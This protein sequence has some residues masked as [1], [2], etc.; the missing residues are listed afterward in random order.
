MRKHFALLIVSFLVTLNILGQEEKQR[1]FEINGTI[2]ADTGKVHLSFVHDYNLNHIDELVVPIKDNK[3]T[4]SGYITEPQ[5]VLILM[6]DFYR[7]SYFIIDKGTQTVT[8]NINN[9]DEVPDIKNHFMLNEYPNYKAYFKAMTTKWDTYYSKRD[10]LSTVYQRNIPQAIRLNLDNEYNTLCKEDDQL[11]LKYSEKN[12]N[13]Y[14]TFWK[15]VRLMGWGYESIYDSIY[16]NFSHQLQNGYAGKVLKQKLSSGKILSIGNYFPLIPS[17]DKDG[18]ALSLNLFKEKELTLVDIWYSGCGPCIAQ[19]NTLKSL[20]NQY[21]HSGFEIIGIS[22]D[23]EMDREKWLDIIHDQN[24][25]WK[26]YWDM[27][28]VETLKLSIV[29]IPQNFLIDKSGKIIAKNISMAELE[30]VLKEQLN[31]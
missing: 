11:L 2:N 5:Q 18:N 8:V 29:V 22:K 9:F 12:P 7:S 30:K 1:Y 28:G 27:N 31:Q 13:S 4:F 3:F 23:K 17:I 6:D 21:N 25:N 26:N 15:L 16:S 10:S 24:I 19:F 14:F 20:Y